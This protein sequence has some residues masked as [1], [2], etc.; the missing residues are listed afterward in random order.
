MRENFLCFFLF[1]IYPELSYIA[2]EVRGITV[3]AVRMSWVASFTLALYKANAKMVAAK[4]IIAEKVSKSG[5]RDHELYNDFVLINSW[6][7]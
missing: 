2:V 6:H 4:I 7:K 5:C 1:D 3:G